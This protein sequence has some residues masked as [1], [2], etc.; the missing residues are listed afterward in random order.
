VVTIIPHHESIPPQGLGS[1][2]RL[3]SSLGKDAVVDHFLIVVDSRMLFGIGVFNPQFSLNLYEFISGKRF[4]SVFIPFSRVEV[5]DFVLSK[6]V[7]PPATQRS[8]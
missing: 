4:F 8:V 1:E 3:K 6:R 5:E 2:R 7:H